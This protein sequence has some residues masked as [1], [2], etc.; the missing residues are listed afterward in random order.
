MKPNFIYIL[1][2]AIGHNL[3]IACFAQNSELGF[4]EHWNRKKFPEG[5]SFY[6]D[7]NSSSSSPFALQSVLRFS[8]EIPQKLSNQNAGLW[9]KMPIDSSWKKEKQYLLI[10]NF[11]INYIQ[12]FYLHHHVAVD[13]SGITGDHYP[14]YNRLV[15]Y[16]EIIIPL[17]AENHIDELLIHLEKRNEPFFTSIQ[18]V[19]GTELEI[20]K[21]N[22]YL[23][24]G[25]ILGIMLTALIINLYVVFNAKLTLSFLYSFFL[26][27]CIVYTLTDFGYIQWVFNISHPLINDS[28]RP[29]TLSLAFCCY[30]F[31]FK[32]TFIHRDQHALLN[33]GLSIYSWSWLGF[34]LS[35]A[36][37]SPFTYGYPAQYYLLSI[38]FFL[39]QGAILWV[40]IGSWMQIKKNTRYALPFLITSLL[41]IVAHIQYM[42]HRYNIT[43]GSII[44]QH[45]VPI[46]LALDCLIIGGIVAATFLEIQEDNQ[47][48]SFRL[49][50]K[51]SE[52]KDRIAEI[53]IRELSRIS[54]LLHNHIITEVITLKNKIE[55]NKEKMGPDTSNDILIQTSR[56][57]EDLRNTSHYLSPQILEK[58]G[59]VHCISLFTK[60]VT[61]TKQIDSYIEISESCNELPMNLQLTL[62]L[63][64]QECVNNTIQHAQARNIEVQCFIENQTLY[65]LY[66]D[67]GIGIHPNAFPKGLGHL[68]MKEMIE[69]HNGTFHIESAIEG[70]IQIE[71]QIPLP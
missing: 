68:Q 39:Q 69:I 46:I 44:H 71:A 15:A 61:Q 23:L 34:I 20:R 3:P 1:I 62:L 32:H 2:I 65:L 45:F 48:L 27:L 50:Q 22:F 33:K 42:F 21:K 5:S 18:I 24:S 26:A 36:C 60:E 12:T 43:N 8:S 38:S 37:T 55:I 17:P 41:F 10:P 40:I 25:T 67:D 53:Q 19:N 51:E 6:W 7:E 59:L 66:S 47:K 11:H 28:L 4:Y 64:I 54:Q 13:S 9:I 29:L 57:L 52:I 14:F 31:F 49:I 63:T 35:V 58:F 56:I 70:G 30:L 16:P